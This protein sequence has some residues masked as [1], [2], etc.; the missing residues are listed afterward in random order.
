[1]ADESFD[2][3]VHNS[4]W[5]NQPD[6]HLL[7]GRWTTPAWSQRDGLPQYVYEEDGGEL[8]TFER[9]DLITYPDCLQLMQ[10]D[11]T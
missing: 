10:K 1:M 5:T 4:D 8:Y 3:L 9:E 6:V 11:L 2:V 7:C